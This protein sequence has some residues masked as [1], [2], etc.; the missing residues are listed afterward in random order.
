M[1][2]P[3]QRRR[4]DDML[5]SHSDKLKP[6]NELKDFGEENVWWVVRTIYALTDETPRALREELSKRLAYVSNPLLETYLTDIIK[7][8]NPS[9]LLESYYWL[10]YLDKQ[11]EF[12][13]LIKVT[14]AS[15]DMVCRLL[16]LKEH[17]KHLQQCVNK[18]IPEIDNKVLWSNRPKEAHRRLKEMKEITHY[19]HYEPF[20]A[21]C[22]PNFLEE[23]FQTLSLFLDH[24]YIG[25]L[26]HVGLGIGVLYIDDM[27]MYCVGNMNILIL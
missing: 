23:D 16:G 27:K 10:E 6:L 18:C 2:T 3:Y 4:L 8:K 13:D 19:P 14:G 12:V 21:Y 22:V 20:V 1:Y 24:F 7:N 17:I 15:P 5:L 11:S 26:K 9:K 25:L